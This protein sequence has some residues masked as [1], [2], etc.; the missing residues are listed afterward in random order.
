[1]NKKLVYILGKPFWKMPDGTFANA[2]VH[3]GMPVENVILRK[4][5]VTAVR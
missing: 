2:V 1:M 5:A 3:N 4:P